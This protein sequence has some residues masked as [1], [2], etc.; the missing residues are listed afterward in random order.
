MSR[1][2]VLFRRGIAGRAKGNGIFH[3]PRFEVA[4]NAKVDQADQPFSSQHDI[5]WFSGHG[6]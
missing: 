4:G 1:F 2:A 3:L 6:R 5:G